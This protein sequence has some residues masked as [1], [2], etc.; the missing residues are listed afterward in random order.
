MKN[1]T[2]VTVK[3]SFN[4]ARARV[5]WRD[6]VLR[7]FTL[8][9]LALDLPASAPKKRPG[10]VHTYDVDLGGKGTITLRGKC[11]TCG[12]RKWWKIAYR[13]ANLLWEAK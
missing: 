10:Y 4:F 9:G 5:I 8:E 3:G 11:V 6:G 12:G 1:F 2:T 13:P 7:V